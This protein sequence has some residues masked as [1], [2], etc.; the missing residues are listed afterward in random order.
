MFSSIMSTNKL[1]L[2]VHL[3]ETFYFCYISSNSPCGPL[4]YTLNSFQIKNQI[5]R[6]IHYLSLCVGSV[7]VEFFCFKLH[8]IFKHFLVAN[9][10]HLNISWLICLNPILLKVPELVIYAC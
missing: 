2:K 10:P 5:H 1:P 9:G 6:Y 8:K 7:N 4:I 3:Q